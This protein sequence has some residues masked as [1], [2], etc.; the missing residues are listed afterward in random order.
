MLQRIYLAKAT[1]AKQ[2]NW[3]FAYTETCA[4]AICKITV[5]RLR[6]VTQ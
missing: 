6:K 2:N 4:K 3:F 1:V 5:A